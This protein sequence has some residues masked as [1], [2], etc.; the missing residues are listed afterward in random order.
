ME[1][2]RCWEPVPP[3][4]GSGHRYYDPFRSRERTLRHI[5]SC[6]PQTISHVLARLP[7]TIY[8]V[9]SVMINKQ[10]SYSRR[11]RSKKWTQCSP[12]P[13]PHWWSSAH[14]IYHASY[15]RS[16]SLQ[17]RVLFALFAVVN[18]AETSAAPA[19]LRIKR[20][21]FPQIAVA[22]LHWLQQT[23]AKVHVLHVK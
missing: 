22:T 17:Q 18:A 10:E 23:P 1:D 3:A 16:L 9:P 19:F 14:T 8:L 21:M 5:L 12:Q 15:P 13:L 7:T 20:S 2:W 6:W 11:R 4:P